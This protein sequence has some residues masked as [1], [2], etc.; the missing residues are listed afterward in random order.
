MTESAP[1]GDLVLLVADSH[2]KSGLGVLLG[3]RYRSLDIRQISFE[4]YAHQ[5]HDPGCLLRSCEFLRNF[6]GRFS[7]AL[8][9]F[10][11]DGC[12]QEHLD[13]GSLER[14]VEAELSA[15]G[16]HDNAATVVIDPELE[17]W[18]WSDS[19]H[20]A[21]ALGWHDIVSLR[22]A[23]QDSALTLPGQMKPARP[24]ECLHFAL[25]KAGRPRSPAVY[26]ELAR[27]V[28]THRCQD[29]ALLKLRSTLQRWFGQGTAE[30]PV[31]GERPTIGIE[32]LTL[33][34]TGA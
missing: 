23:L 9:V 3:E 16:W 4:V 22:Q 28:S 2:Q 33:P 6:Q 26:V 29:P 24:K 31:V 18:V 5:G 30:V 10:D 19:P 7:H 12:G 8:V 17:S 1:G 34:V 13:R 11:R 14:V 27:T 20:V 21:T 32:Q 15:S 25:R